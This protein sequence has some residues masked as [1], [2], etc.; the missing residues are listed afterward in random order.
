[1]SHVFI[2]YSHAD[3]EYARRLADVL[4]QHGYQ[5]WIDDRIDYGSHWPSVIQENLDSCAAFIVIMS[6]RS[7]ASSWVQN[8]LNRAMRKGKPLFPLLL[9]GDEPWLAVESTQYVDVRG[10]KMPPQDFYRQLTRA[11][12]RAGH[13]ANAESSDWYGFRC[14]RDYQPGDLGS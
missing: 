4:G 8:E 6:P 7:F 2:S 3:S 13:A 14:V 1:M 9:D 5:V 12:A 10:G 11:A